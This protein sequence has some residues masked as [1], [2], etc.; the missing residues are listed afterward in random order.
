MS[1]IPVFDKNFVFPKKEDFKRFK[2][3]IFNNE[4]WKVKY[5]KDQMKVLTKTVC[6]ILI[7]SLFIFLE[8]F[9]FFFKFINSEIRACKVH[10]IINDIDPRMLNMQNM[11]FKYLILIY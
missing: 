7:I 11:M 4:G 3:G 8:L 9:I 6:N 10:S 1:D 5:C 2:D